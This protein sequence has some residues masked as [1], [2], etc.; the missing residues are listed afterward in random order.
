M[1][2][3]KTVNKLLSRFE[4]PSSKFKF[5]KFFGKYPRYLDLATPPASGGTTQS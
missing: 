3:K 2:V 5:A 1:L 4:H